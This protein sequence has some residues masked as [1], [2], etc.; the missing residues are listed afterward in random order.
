MP[1][2]GGEE[3][4]WGGYLEGGGQGSECCRRGCASTRF[5]LSWRTF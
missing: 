1:G 4:G 3:G 5:R 2:S